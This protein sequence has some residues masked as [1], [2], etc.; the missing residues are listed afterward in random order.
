MLQC[1]QDR[2]D[3]QQK[4]I[5]D[6]KKVVEAQRQEK[7]LLK[8][9][10]EAQRQEKQQLEQKVAE[11]DNKITRFHRRPDKRYYKYSNGT[12]HDLKTGLIWLQN[13]NCFGEKKWHEAMQLAANLRSG[14]CGLTDGST[15][16]MWRL[17]TV[18]ELGAILEMRYQGP[19]LSNHNET[20]QWKEGDPFSS[21]QANDYWTS[22]EYA[23]GSDY[24]W[25][26]NLDY[27]VVYNTS[28]KTYTG[29]VW[30]VRR[31]Q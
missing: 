15:A 30:P 20:A 18:E 12:V 3:D 22:T 25:G 11:M 14:Q 1:L 10:V 28:G 13:A 17:P 21:V 26:V 23:H 6:L 8:K 7:Q 5:A 4:Q 16:G 29:Y 24:A 27:G 9:V 31:R 19:A 2:D